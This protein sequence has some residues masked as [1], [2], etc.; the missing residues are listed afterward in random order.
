MDEPF[1]GFDLRQ[2]REIMARGSR[3]GGAMGARSCLAIHQ[4]IDA[5]RVCDR[6]VLL[7]DGRVRGVGTLASCARRPRWPPPDWR[8]SSLRSPDAVG[9]SACSPAPVAGQGAAGD[10]ERPRAVDHAADPLPARRLQLLPGRRRSMAR[11]A[12]RRAMH[13]RLRAASRRSTACWCPPSARS[14]SPST[15]LFPFVAI[16]S[17][18]REKENRRAASAGAV[19]LSGADAD[20]RQDGGDLRRLAASQLI[21]AVSAVVIWAMLGGHLY[22]PETANLLSGHLLYGLLVGAIAL[23]AAQRFPKARRRRRSSPW[24]SPSAPGFWISPWPASRA[25]FEWVSRLSLT[26]TLRTFEQGSSVAGSVLGVMAAICG[27]ARAVRGVAASRSAAAHQVHAFDRLRRRRCGRARTGHA[28]QDIGGPHR[29]SAQLVSS[30]RSARARRASRAAARSPF[31]LAPEDPRYVDL[32]R[33]VLAK[34]ER[35]LPTSAIRLA[36]SGPKRR[37]Q[38][39]RRGLWRDRL[40]LR[41]P[42]RTRA[43]RPARAKSCRCSMRLRDAPSRRRAP[44]GV[45]RLPVGRRRRDGRAPVVPRRPP[46]A[47]RPRLVVEPPRTAHPAQLIK[48]GGQP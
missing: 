19:A 31:D 26:Q 21:P 38:Q 42:R 32:R 17:L 15:L 40:F 37:G 11:R 33:N 34:L 18:G 4:L 22:V 9:R 28:G 35:A 29:G 14:T 41:G 45:S 5:E 12:R 46:A 13:R 25:C 47:D 23:F 43:A 8:T 3:R 20:R 36:T 2:T 16:R 6:F 7:A 48:E 30:R 1:D 10:R 39:Q 44:G 27:F 24:P